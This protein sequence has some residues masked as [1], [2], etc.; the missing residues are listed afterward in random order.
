LEALEEF[1]LQIILLLLLPVLVSEIPLLFQ[2][3]SKVLVLEL[4]VLALLLE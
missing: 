1:V 4:Q 3:H 2:A